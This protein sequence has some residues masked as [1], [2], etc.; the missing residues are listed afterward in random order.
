MA[1]TLRIGT[2]DSALAMWQAK[3]VQSQ[4]ATHRIASELVPVKSLGDLKLDQPLYELGVTGVFTKTLDLA[5]LAG[6]IDLAVHSY[7][8]VPTVLAKG[9][10]T[11]AVLKRASTADVLVHKSPDFTTSGLQI[12]TSSLRR[13]AQWLAKYPEHQLVDIRGNVQTRLE[14]LANNSWGGAIFAAAGL[15]RLDLLPENAMR[16]DWMVPAPAQGAMVVVAQSAHTV[17]LEELSVL[18]DFQTALCTQI[19][20]EFLNELEGGCTAPI[21]ALCTTTQDQLHFIGVLHSLDGKQHI[22]T[23][24]FVPLDQAPG[25]GRKMAQ[26]IL[27]QGGKALMAEIKKALS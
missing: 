15:A 7:K 2:R 26:K 1:K 9:L 16:L 10:S 23:N 14:K 20:R 5:L 6:E 19:E 21:G 27:S 18:N 11:A 4:L 12:A 25:Y 3:T 22:E 17:L 24:T 13:K 8:D